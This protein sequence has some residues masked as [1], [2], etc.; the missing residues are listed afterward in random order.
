MQN[1]KCKI[2]GE[3]HGRLLTKQKNYIKPVGATIGGCHIKKAKTVLIYGLGSVC[4]IKFFR[5]IDESSEV[6]ERDVIISCKNY[7]FVHR[8]FALSAF[9]KLILLAGHLEYFCNIPLRFVRIFSHISQPLVIMHSVS[10]NCIYIN[11][12]Y[13]FLGVSTSPAR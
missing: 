1:A 5:R 13:S 11:H 10:H 12:Q 9:V 3:P 8:K 7:E 2:G 4:S 6:I